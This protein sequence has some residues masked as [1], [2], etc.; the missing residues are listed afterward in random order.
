[1]CGMTSYGKCGEW[2]TNVNVSK[3]YDTYVHSYIIFLSLN[4]KKIYWFSFPGF[5]FSQIH[6]LLLLQT[7]LFLPT[8]SL[9]F[10]ANLFS[11]SSINSHC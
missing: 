6:S 3:C 11:F 5:L 10:D 4:T 1:M 2:D 7:F 9:S 8:Q